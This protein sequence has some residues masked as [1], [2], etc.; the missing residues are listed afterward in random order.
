MHHRD[1]WKERQQAAQRAARECGLSGDRAPL[2]DG[3]DLLSL[4]YE[5][6]QADRFLSLDQALDVAAMDQ[7]RLTDYAADWTVG[8]AEAWAD[9]HQFAQDWDRRCRFHYGLQLPVGVIED[10]DDEDDDATP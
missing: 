5:I 8:S 10:A 6:M 1:A 9:A 4:A 2:T 7:R 3:P